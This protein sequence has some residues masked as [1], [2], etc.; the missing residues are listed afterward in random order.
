MDSS[1]TST[2]SESEIS[3]I[4]KFKIQKQQQCIIYK[5]IGG[6]L[7]ESTDKT[8]FTFMNS[9]KIRDY[10]NKESDEDYKK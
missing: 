2:S 10:I 5:K 9:T 7:I 8:F 6:N 3:S 1:T 4:V